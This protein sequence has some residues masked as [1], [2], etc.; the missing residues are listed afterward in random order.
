MA[1]EGDDGV[2]EMF[3]ELRNMLPLRYK[4]A[5]NDQQHQKIKWMADYVNDTIAER[6]L[7]SNGE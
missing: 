2:P 7:P 6:N 1:A 4:N 3:D 5:E